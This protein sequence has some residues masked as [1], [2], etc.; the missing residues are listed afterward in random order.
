[1][2]VRKPL[3]AAGIRG[4]DLARRASGGRA[5]ALAHDSPRAEGMTGSM[6]ALERQKDLG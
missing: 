6:R 1:M 2:N 3:G 5:P 4:Q